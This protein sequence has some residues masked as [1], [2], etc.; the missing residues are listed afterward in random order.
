MKSFSGRIAVVTGGGSGMGRELVRQLSAEGCHVAT[1]DVDRE[2]VSETRDIA[3]GEA[4][5]A[6][7]VTAATTDVAHED[8]LESFRDFVVAELRTGHVDLLFNNAGIGGGGSF[9]SDDRTEWDRTFAID[10]GGVYHSTR[11][12]LPMLVASEEGHVVNTSS[13]NGVWASVGPSTPHTA[14]CASKFAIRGFTEALITDFRV[15]APH[16][17]AHVV[18]PGHIGTSII[19]NSGKVHGKDPGSWG[20]DDFAA[21]RKRLSLSGVPVDDVSDDD[22]RSGFEVIAQKFRD[23]APMSAAVAATVILDGVR[24]NRWRIIVG[25]DAEIIDQEVRSD[26]DHAYELEF[27]RALRDKEV[28]SLLSL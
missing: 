1:C 3:L 23:E 16:V 19:I 11:V 14:Y 7:R 28:F 22:L 18:M 4:P 15:N 21:L 24:E 25:A 8:Q 2:A 26:P 9:V 6:T 12:F 13:I 17:H 20:P 10:W 5:P 27:W